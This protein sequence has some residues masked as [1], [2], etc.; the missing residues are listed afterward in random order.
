MDLLQWGYWR[1]DN[2]NQD[3]L[4]GLP[5]KQIK[6]P[7]EHTLKNIGQ[8]PVRPEWVSPSCA[9]TIVRFVSFN[10]PMRVLSGYLAM[11]DFDDL[12]RLDQPDST[13]LES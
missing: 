5:L 13:P 9:H 3:P 10:K 8:V 2:A 12:D 7:E 6:Q 4:C 11:F 1:F